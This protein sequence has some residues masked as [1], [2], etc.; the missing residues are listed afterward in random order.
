MQLG[1]SLQNNWGVEDVQSLVQ[2]GRK[3]EEW[4]F[5]SKTCVFTPSHQTSILMAY[6]SRTPAGM[7]LAW[8]AK[9]RGRRCHRGPM[10]FRPLRVKGAFCALTAYSGDSCH[11]IRCKA[12][13]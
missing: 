13:T 11:P 3:A 9:A 12:A 4:G 1:I 7:T 5:A 10:F 8:G 2:L 6:I